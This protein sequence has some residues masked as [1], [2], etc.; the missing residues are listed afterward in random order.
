VPSAYREFATPPGLERHVACLWTSHDRAT[1]VLPDAC[2]DI[3]LDGGRLL[4]AGPATEVV[5]VPDTPG[6][7]RVGVRFRVG[8]AG[9]ALGLPASELLNQ[10][11]LLEELWGRA[12][13]R[14]EQ[15]VAGAATPEEA[16]VALARGVAERLPAPGDGDPLVRQAALALVRGGFSLRDTG[17][18][19]GLGERQ[20]RRRFERAV[21]YGPATLVR[22]QRFQRFL[23][24]AERDPA[25]GLARLAFESGYADQAHLTR[26]CQRLAGRSPGTLLRDGSTAAGEK[27]VSFDPIGAAAPTLAA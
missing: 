23:A 19:V 13:R 10:G 12:G 17:R 24:L 8:S 2:A 6:Q 3:V 4:V 18:L 9:A 14:L 27:S 25:G 21:G 5:D 16:V 15:R 26:E 11:V 1:R 20:L 7:H 22:I